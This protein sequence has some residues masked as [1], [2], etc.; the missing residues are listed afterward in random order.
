M[1]PEAARAAYAA[2]FLERPVSI[3]LFS[4]ALGLDRP[5][6]DFGVTAWST[7]IY[8]A[9]MR[10]LAD[11]REA[12]PLL[13]AAPGDRAPPFIL[14]DYGRLDTGLNADGLRLAS[15]TGVDRLENWQGLD[16]AALRARR[17][18]WMDRLV[19]LL[20]AEFPG[21]AGAVRQRQMS[22][23]ASMAHHLGTP[24]GAVYGFRPYLE[25]GGLF[26]RGP[27]TPVPGLFHASAFTA[28]GGFT[29]AMMGGAAAARVAMGEGG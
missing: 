20:D 8:P 14:V 17:E 15:V 4:L 22:T 28:G 23:A 7:C 9:W 16:P 19:A 18:A 13:G 21:I 29:G 1:L 3:S 11:L 27:K 2:A 10:R 26:A 24:G 25:A 5:A 12:A 6:S